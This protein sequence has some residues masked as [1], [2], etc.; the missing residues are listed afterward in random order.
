MTPI[1][2]L[3][4]AL[5]VQI[6]VF[7]VA[8]VD[9]PSDD[10]LAYSENAHAIATDFDEFF[11]D[12]PNHPF[13]MR[14]GITMP[15][16][17][18]YRVVGAGPLTT[19]LPSLLAA[20]AILLV[21]YTAAPTAHAKLAGIGFTVCSTL[22]M[23]HASELDVD[24]L[25]GAAIAVM[26]LLLSRRD[27]STWLIA[28]AVVVWFFAFLIKE[29][30]IWFAPAW[31]YAIVVDLRA[32]GWRTVARTYAPPLVIGL[33][34][35]IGYLAICAYVWNDP[36]AR[37]AGIDG[38]AG[39][40]LWSSRGYST[41]R[42]IERLTWGPPWLFA[43]TLGLPFLVAVVGARRITGPDR[44]WLVAT[45]GFLVMFWF[46]SASTRTYEPLPLHERM[47]LPALPG[48]LVLATTASAKLTW[49][50]IWIAVI[51]LATVVPYT[52][53]VE[54]AARRELPE[55]ATYAALRAEVA[56]EP[57]RAFVI[58]CPE[59]RCL[60]VS[61]FQFRFA[62]PANVRIAHARDFASS[63]LVSG[64]KVRVIV[65]LRHA[66]DPS[67]DARISALGLP[68]TASHRHV[69]LYDAGDGL[70][71]HAALHERD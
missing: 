15:L 67:I 11:T 37:F 23:R 33:V 21:V 63:P 34:L 25:C 31:I 38:L 9:T 64:A 43:T 22:L 24:L 58:V 49:N 32:A 42:W 54:T 2:V 6:A 60:S 51:A 35:A 65:N 12:P 14:V 19:H 70:R 28:G 46:G 20:V 53:A 57:T 17:V 13:A 52:K 39:Q 44:L 55:T 10:P 30:A 45:A 36:L 29:T 7:V 4:I 56:A 41:A 50:R 1:R 8:R 71:L 26:L 16:A 27:R 66:R 61:R 48:V 3:A 5:T 59:V 40:H 18:I 47:I 68:P 69:R 62:P